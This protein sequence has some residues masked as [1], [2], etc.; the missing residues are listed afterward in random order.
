MALGALVLCTLSFQR[1]YAVRAAYDVNGFWVK[2]VFGRNAWQASPLWAAGMASG[3]GA[4]LVWFGALKRLEQR[5]QRLVAAVLLLTAVALVAQ[6]HRPYHRRTGTYTTTA[7]YRGDGNGNVI[8]ANGDPIALRDLHSA[9]TEPAQRA[10]LITLA[11]MLGVVLLTPRGSPNP[12]A[13]A[14]RRP[15][16]GD[17]DE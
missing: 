5:Q 8:S 11:V 2:T 16:L 13:R 9:G 15:E 12:A 1:W 6:E 7:L 4:V 3:F 14:P 17:G 10:T